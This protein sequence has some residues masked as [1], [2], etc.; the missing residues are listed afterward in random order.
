MTLD[1]KPWKQFR[2]RA[3]VDHKEN[4]KFS[5]SQTIAAAH[6]I[7]TLLLVYT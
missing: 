7:E 3:F 6:D 2:R 5:F 1:E 4:I